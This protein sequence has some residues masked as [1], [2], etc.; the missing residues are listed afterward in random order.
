[1]KYLLIPVET[2]NTLYKVI[3]VSTAQYYYSSG[4][5]MAHSRGTSAHKHEACFPLL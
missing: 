5:E 3:K 4:K 1:M 2:T